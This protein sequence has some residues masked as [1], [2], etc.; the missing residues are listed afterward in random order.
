MVFHKQ[1]MLLNNVYSITEMKDFPGLRISLLKIYPFT[2]EQLN[3][4]A[5]R[6]TFKKLEKKSFLLKPNQIS[7]CLTFI[8]SGSLRFYTDTERSELT[9][10][11][12]TENQW[13]ADIESFLM[14]QPSKN[15]IEAFE[16]SDIA[17]ITLIHIHE[18]MDIYP[19]FRM[20]NALI[21]NLTIPTTHLA[22][23]STKNPDERYKELLL[24]HPDWINRFPQMQ[25]ASY[26]GMTP[27][28]LSRVRARVA[29]FLA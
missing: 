6:L 7:N 28:T 22:T 13:A 9:I 1:L 2:E 3:Q 11:F 25:I 12:F 26:L 23:I 27:E 20:L 15:Y 19:C 8:N 4:F 29:S 16:N 14:Q 21:A 10:K 18:L 17:S 5:D 24:K